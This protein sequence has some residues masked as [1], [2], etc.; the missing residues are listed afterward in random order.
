M[1]TR[2]LLQRFFGGIWARSVSIAI[3]IVTGVFLKSYPK[4][5]LRNPKT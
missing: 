3:L 2:H 5:I 4:N 1:K